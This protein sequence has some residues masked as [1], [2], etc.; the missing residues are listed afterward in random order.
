MAKDLA[1]VN[2]P[3]KKAPPKKKA[4]TTKQAK[5]AAPIVPIRQKL[6]S[7]PRAG[8]KKSTRKV[9]IVLPEHVGGAGV[10]VAKTA[11]RTINLP[12]RFR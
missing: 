9:D 3:A 10:V 5:N 4:T 11:S 1:A 2:K 12:R 6:S 7:R 8:A